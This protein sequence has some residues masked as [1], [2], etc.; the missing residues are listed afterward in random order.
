MGE[1]ETVFVE[2]LDDLLVGRVRVLT[3]VS[4]PVDIEK[5]P[6]PAIEQLPVDR[7][8]GGSCPDKPGLPV[9]V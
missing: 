4:Q 3:V 1:A 7:A 6:A 8:R 2:L 9:L 5:S